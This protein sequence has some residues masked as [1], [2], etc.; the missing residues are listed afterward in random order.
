MAAALPRTSCFVEDAQDSFA[1]YE[2]QRRHHARQGSGLEPFIAA[3]EAAVDSTQSGQCLGD[4]VLLH[5]YELAAFGRMNRLTAPEHCPIGGAL[6]VG[7]EVY[8]REW[9]FG[10][11]K[12]QGSGVICEFPRSNRKYFFRE[13]VVLGQTNLS[14]GEVALV[15]GDLLERWMPNDYH[16]LHKN[17]LNFANALCERLGVGRIPP[18]IDRFARGAGAVD[19]GVRGIAG[20]VVESVHGVAEGARDVMRA[21]VEGPSSCGQFQCRSASKLRCQGEGCQRLCTVGKGSTIVDGTFLP[22]SKSIF[23]VVNDPDE[24]IVYDTSSFAARLPFIAAL[25]ESED[26]SSGAIRDDEVFTTTA[27]R[28]QGYR[29][30]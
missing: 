22:V 28:W 23:E 13:T 18:W 29:C 6:H 27:A 26:A 25:A 3:I 19:M 2:T 14:D 12:G 8:G 7:I 5:V 1:P 17:C 16:W 4:Q 9:S 21:L 24:R 15:I 30:K 20:G 11:G 10:G